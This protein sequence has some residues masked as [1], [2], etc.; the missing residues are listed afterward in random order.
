MLELLDEL[1]IMTGQ[2]AAHGLVF[3][4]WN[5]HGWQY[6]GNNYHSLL[7]LIYG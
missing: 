4:E 1:L 2:R 6:G 3:G 5:R 7:E